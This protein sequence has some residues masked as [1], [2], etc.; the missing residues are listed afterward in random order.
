MQVFNHQF[1]LTRIKDISILGIFEKASIDLLVQPLAVRQELLKLSG[2]GSLEE[3]MHIQKAELMFSRPSLKGFLWLGLFVL[4]SYSSGILPMTAEV[5]DE[6]KLPCK[7][8]IPSHTSL[9]S[10]IVYWQKHI[11][12]RKDLVAI[13]YKDGKEMSDSKDPYYINRTRMNEQNFT[14][15]ISSVKV[16]D[17]G[18]YKCIIILESDKISETYVSLSVIAAFS[19]PKIYA[20]QFNACGPTQLTLRCFSYGGYPEPTMSGLINNETVEWSYTSIPDNQT[21]L[22]NITGILT[23]NFTE[24]SVV[25]CSVMSNFNV[26]TNQRITRK[27]PSAVP[28]SQLFVI[29]ICLVAVVGPIMLLLYHIVHK[30]SRSSCRT[31]HNQPVLKVEMTSQPHSNGTSGTASF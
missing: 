16:S 1:L 5:G 29:P 19:K 22:F 30:R 8:K 7:F 26:S 20:E 23:L 17:K 3:M 6:V 31:S 12:G 15:F 2:I 27:C 9:K 10:Y 13:A 24:D 14:L 18:T 11:E 28:S 4:Q 25:H 21:E